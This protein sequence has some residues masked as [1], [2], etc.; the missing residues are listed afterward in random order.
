[1]DQKQAMA[2]IVYLQR[3]YAIIPTTGA[4]WSALSSAVSAIEGV[5]NGVT[6]MEVKPGTT[7]DSEAAQARRP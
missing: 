7:A 4:E 6:T 3:A 2:L 5:A 1:L